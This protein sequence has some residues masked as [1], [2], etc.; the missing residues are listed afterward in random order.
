MR[1]TGINMNKVGATEWF[2]TY[3]G[4]YVQ[5]AAGVL[6]GGG[7]PFDPAV[8]SQL[9][10]GARAFA[11]ASLTPQPGTPEFISLFNKVTSDPNVSTGSKFLD[12]TKMHIAEGNYN[13]KRLLNDQVDLQVGGSYRQYSLDS[14][15]TIFTDYDGSIDYNEY[16]AY[17]QA[18]KKF[19]DDRLK[20]FSIY[21]L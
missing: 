14:G 15:G 1:F 5:G 17:I 11:D 3:A 10:A 19:A 8:Q 6:A 12:N 2:G 7:N 21:T 16:G 20:S 13:F 18:I 9:H 4:A